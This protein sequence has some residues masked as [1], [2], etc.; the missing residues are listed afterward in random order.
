MNNSTTF[1]SKIRV[2]ILFGGKSAE[3]EISIQSAGNVANALDRTRFELTLVGI[4]TQGGW[5]AVEKPDDLAQVTAHTTQP[6]LT[7]LKDTDVVF[8]ILHG[9]MGEDGTIQGLFELMN[10]PYVG[11]NVLSSAVGMDKDVMK[12][13][14]READILVAPFMTVT[15][16]ERPNFDPKSVVETLGSPLF[17]KPA[18]MGS[19]IGVSRVTDVNELAAAVDNALRFDTKVLLETA[20]VGDEIECAILGNEDP[21]ASVIGRIIPDDS[22]YSYDAKYDSEHTTGLEIPAKLS[23]TQAEQARQTALR[24]YRV[25]GC[26]GLSR[27]DM[28]ALANGDIVVNEI[29]TL[30]GFTAISMYPKLWEAS[31]ITYTELITRLLELALERA[32]KRS[33]LQTAH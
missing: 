20:I 30:P 14:L 2:A 4:D 6:D 28:F 18:N 10:L 27:V 12:R 22:F 33:N 31:G 24:V 23:E 5:H 13:L 29:N 32:Q 3:H 17:V 21:K 8:P 25:L 19:S 11:P 1:A 9:P 26:E 15:A 16:P 7:L